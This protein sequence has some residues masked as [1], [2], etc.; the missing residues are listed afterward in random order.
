MEM[1]PQV[2]KQQVR[3]LAASQD[4]QSLRD[5]AAL[6]AFGNRLPVLQAFQEFLDIERRK[7]RRRLAATA[8]GFLA[9]LFGILVAGGVF[10]VQFAG[11]VDR[12]VRQLEQ[13]LAAARD[14]TGSL[15]GDAQA[16]QRALDSAQAALQALQQQFAALPARGPSIDLAAVAATL[17]LLQST[18]RLQAEQEALR[19]RLAAVDAEVDAVAAREAE[20]AAQESQLRDSAQRWAAAVT[21][22]EARRGAAQSR[23]E[24]LS[25][26]PEAPAPAE[27]SRQLFR[28]K[29]DAAPPAPSSVP[30]PDPQ[31]VLALLE[32]LNEIRNAQPALWARYYRLMQDAEQVARN[33]QALVQQRTALAVARERASEEVAKWH[34]RHA[35]I[36]AQFAALREA[37]APTH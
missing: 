12:D 21:D 3:S 7:A 15:R 31:Q 14:E 19:E 27:P 13:A 28:R 30:T 37:R 34:E 10:F 25:T 35:G 9:V 4:M 23:L 20:H 22:L 2:L 26:P 16:M 8:L 24:V 5:G 6:Q 11:R 32:E 33:E 1:P 29:R 17:D 36:T 18:Q